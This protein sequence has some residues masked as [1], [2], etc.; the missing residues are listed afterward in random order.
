MELPL[1]P[2][3]VMTLLLA[4]AIRYTSLEFNS[5]LYLIPVMVSA[6]RWGINCFRWRGR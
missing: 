6:M 5:I 2:V 4:V 3:G 1:L